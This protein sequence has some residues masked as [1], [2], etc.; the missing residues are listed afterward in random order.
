MSEVVEMFIALSA[1]LFLL[2][3]YDELRARPC[4]DQT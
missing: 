1:L 3:R 4:P 2:L